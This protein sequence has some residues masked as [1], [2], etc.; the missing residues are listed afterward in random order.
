MGTFNMET[1][2]QKNIFR[3]KVLIAYFSRSGN[4]KAVAN[5][6]KNLTGGDLFESR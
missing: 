4:T 3:Q 6:I 2:A 5:H 1:K